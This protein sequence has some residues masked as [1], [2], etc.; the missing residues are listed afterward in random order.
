MSC[1]GPQPKRFVPSPRARD[2][3]IAILA[4]QTRHAVKPGLTR[5]AQVQNT[6][7]TVREQAMNELQYDLQYVDQHSLLFDVWILG[8]TIR[9]VFSGRENRQHN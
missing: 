3:D 8:Q 9:L 5:W 7:G 4:F 6:H 1:V 2:S